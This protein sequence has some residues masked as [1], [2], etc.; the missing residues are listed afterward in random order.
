[1]SVP[2][3]RRLLHRW[4]RRRRVGRAY[5]MAKEIARQL[6][7]GQRV[8]DVGCGTGYI[9]HLLTAFLGVPASRIAYDE[10]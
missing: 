9:A 8:L 3:L 6:S 5:D 10:F 1:M 7:P 2:R 4:L